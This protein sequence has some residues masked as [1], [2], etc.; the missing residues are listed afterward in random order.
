MN[1]YASKQESKHFTYLDMNNLYGYATSKF[2]PTKGF[3]RI[4]NQVFDFNKYSSNSSKGCVL[5][6]DLEYP[7]ELW[8]LHSD[9]QLAPNNIEINKKM[10]SNYQL[11]IT[12][13]Y[14]IPKN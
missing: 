5:V 8:E 13:L 10:L 3:K 7:K 14:K 2:L 12:D 9:Y 6:V 4:D 1:S 11:K